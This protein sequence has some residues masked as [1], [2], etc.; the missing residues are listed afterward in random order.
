MHNKTHIGL[1]DAHAKSNGSH[2]NDAIFA[3]KTLLV[4]QTLGS[5]EPGMIGQRSEP[6]LLQPK[7]S[8]FSFFARKTINNTGVTVMLALQ[9]IQ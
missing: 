8:L 6:L 9:K 2:H 4:G 3:Q 7:R 1:V 5:A